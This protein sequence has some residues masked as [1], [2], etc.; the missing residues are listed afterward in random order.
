[1]C[2]ILDPEYLQLS[3]KILKWGK[4]NVNVIIASDGL[5]FWYRIMQRNGWNEIK[6]GRKLK[7]E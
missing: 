2:Q 3:D 7:M 4:E 6:D 1:M 5:A